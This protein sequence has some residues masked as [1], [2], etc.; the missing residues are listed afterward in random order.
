LLK[1]CTTKVFC[2]AKRQHR[3]WNT[4]VVGVINWFYDICA[5]PFHSE[6]LAEQKL[7]SL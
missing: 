2:G 6:K 7:M 3:K 4:L 1:A 5:M